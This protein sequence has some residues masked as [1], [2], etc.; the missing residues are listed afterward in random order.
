MTRAAC[1]GVGW[2]GVEFFPPDITGH[3]NWG[4]LF[5]D[6]RAVALCR[7]CPVRKECM[8]FGRGPPTEFGLWGGL[9]FGMG[10]PRAVHEDG[11]IGEPDE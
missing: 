5:V 11:R 6:P 10:K 1:A 7:V 9:M 3:Q 8:V 2:A 4:Q